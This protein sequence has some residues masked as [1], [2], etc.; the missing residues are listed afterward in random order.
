LAKPRFGKEMQVHDSFE[1]VGTAETYPD[2]YNPSGR[3]AG[4]PD[5]GIPF[6]SGC[7]FEKMKDEVLGAGSHELGIGSGLTGGLISDMTIEPH[8]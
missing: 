6:C 2:V 3:V 8:Y 4:I 5:S 1:R 7:R